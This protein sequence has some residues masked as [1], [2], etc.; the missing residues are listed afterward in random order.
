[1]Q[2]LVEF[3]KR[4]NCL[5]I[6]LT[7]AGREE[8]HDTFLL[9]MAEDAALAGLFEHQLCNG[10]QFIAPEEIGA[11][12]AAPILSDDVQR[13]DDG[14]VTAVGAVYWHDNYQ[15]ESA[16]REMYITGYVDFSKVL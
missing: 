12:T 7:D 11:L 4:P 8:I 15:V 9:T 5:R 2:K 3:E 1:M 13:D 14:K 16:V 10:W 6:T